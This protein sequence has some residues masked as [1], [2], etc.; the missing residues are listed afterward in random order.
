MILAP[1][2]NDARPVDT[3]G[4]DS[5][6]P[7]FLMGTKGPRLIAVTSRAA[8]ASRNDNPDHCGGGGIYTLLG[9]KT[10]LDWLEAHGAIGAPSVKV[11]SGS[12]FGELQYE[13]QFS[14]P[15]K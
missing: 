5:G 4:G 8:P 9:R 7:V 3:C 13:L 14:A 1:A 11:S 6:G 15:A 12:P 10:V 2:A